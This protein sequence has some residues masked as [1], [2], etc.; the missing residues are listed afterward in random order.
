MLLTAC[1]GSPSDGPNESAA[2]G[3]NPSGT[4]TFANWQWLEPT[5]GDETWAA[6]SAYTEVNKG[7]KLEKQI[8]TRA[9]YEKTIN[10]QVGAG[11]GPDIFVIADGSY[12]AL[13]ASGALEP[14]DGVLTQEETAALLPVNKD[15]VTDGKQL[16][17][18]WNTTAYALYWNKNIT[19]A[20]GISSV[21]T[22][23]EEL[24]EA[25]KTV[26]DKTGK[27]GFVVRH[28]MNEETPWWSDFSNWAFGY[29][30]AW[31]NGK[32]L[33]INSPENIAGL[34]ALKEIYASGA[35]GIGDD[36]STYRSKFAAGEVG[37]VIDNAA[38]LWTSVAD[39][40][41]V[42]SKAVGAAVL[43]FPGGSSTAIGV[44]I[45]INAHSKN[46]ELAKDF[47]RW[48]F[49]EDAQA[50]L[51]TSLFPGGVGTAATASQDLVNANPWVDAFYKQAAD[52]QNVIVKGFGVKTP[53]I[54]H[55]IL[56][57]VQRLLTSDISAKEAFDTAQKEAEALG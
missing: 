7:A 48:M 19:D 3:E 50:A 1:S 57:Q 8:V 2:P 11:G 25:A 51:A 10:T 6:V 24:I 20:A 23:I 4:L 27:T 43:P 55:I 39:N 35:F 34:A 28:Q 52:S 53:Q 31:S 5:R 56:T 12:P 17:L 47:L 41:I 32:E 30:G 36:A 54:S 14:L 16:A 22:T 26:K 21:P 18:V 13:A 44:T 46:K 33:T 42:P 37:Y 15:Y 45:A 40:D 38:A 9:D 49:T 29:G